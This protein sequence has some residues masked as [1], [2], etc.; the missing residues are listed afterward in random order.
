MLFFVKVRV[1]VNKLMEFGQKLQAG[2]LKTHPLS[3][4]CLKDDA[5]VGLN[6]WEAENRGAFEKA[7]APYKEYYSEVMEIVPIITAQEA[8]KILVE[9]LIERRG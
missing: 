7:F 2:D 1:D 8:Q 3:T 9:Q 6:I 4:Y 5:S